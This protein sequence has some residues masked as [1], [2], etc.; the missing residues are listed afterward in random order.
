MTANSVIVNE[1]RSI[2]GKEDYINYKRNRISL[3]YKDPK[4]ALNTAM[5]SFGSLVDVFFNDAQDKGAT[6]KG[7]RKYLFKRQIEEV[8]RMFPQEVSFN[9]V[10]ISVLPDGSCSRHLRWGLKVSF[11][12]Q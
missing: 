2:L 6:V 1:I 11:S 5:K 8:R 7:F 3:N 12:K 10:L 9:I 4:S